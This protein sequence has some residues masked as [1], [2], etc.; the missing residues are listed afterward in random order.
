MTKINCQVKGKLLAF[1]TYNANEKMTP[2]K[3]QNTR[4]QVGYANEKF[5]VI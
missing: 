3:R 2:T 1:F 5:N 4:N